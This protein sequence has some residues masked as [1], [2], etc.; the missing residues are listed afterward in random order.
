MGDTHG[1]ISY[2]QTNFGYCFQINVEKIFQKDFLKLIMEIYI[3]LNIK[4]RFEKDTHLK[5]VGTDHETLELWL[6]NHI[7]L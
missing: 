3:H 5:K 2:T 4:T 6:N 1:M 7:T